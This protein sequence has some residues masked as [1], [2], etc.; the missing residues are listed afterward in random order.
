[1]RLGIFNETCDAL[2]HSSNIFVSFKQF[3]GLHISFNK[4]NTY[5]LSMYVFAKRFFGVPHLATYISLPYLLE[6]LGTEIDGMALTPF[7]FSIGWTRIRTHGLN[8]EKSSLPT[9]PDFHILFCMLLF[10]Q[11]WTY[12]AKHYSHS[13]IQDNW[14][15]KLERETEEMN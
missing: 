10:V 11:K 8:R 13:K 6:G 9:R 3:Y 5:C 12:L 4:I 2:H 15:F 1:M 7:I 14:K